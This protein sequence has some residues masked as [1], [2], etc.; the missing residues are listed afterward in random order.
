MI[1]SYISR[2]S[3]ALI[4]KDK[5]CTQLSNEFKALEIHLVAK[6][7]ENKGLYFPR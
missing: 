5:E 7:A 4:D 2:A 3:N 6:E 1:L